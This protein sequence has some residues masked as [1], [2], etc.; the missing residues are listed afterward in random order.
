MHAPLI[1]GLGCARVHGLAAG[2][3]Q[4]HP[5]KPSVGSLERAEVGLVGPSGVE[6]G[7]L[8][9]VRIPVNRSIDFGT[10]G[11]V[12]WPCSF[13]AV[14]LARQAQRLAP[15][16]LKGPGC[17]RQCR[18]HRRVPVCPVPQSRCGPVLATILP[19]V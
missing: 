13:A 3:S 4:L 10:F 12:F 6:K 5:G 1:Y 18:M 9:G 8:V 17:Q 15:K 11:I 14:A 19:W 16:L 2:N 7:G